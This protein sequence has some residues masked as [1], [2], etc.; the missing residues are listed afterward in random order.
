MRGKILLLFVITATTLWGQIDMDQVKASEEFAW[1]VRAFHQGRYNESILGFERALSFKPEDKLFRE[2]LGRAYYFSGFE[3]AAIQEWNKVLEGKEDPVIQNWSLTVAG[4]RANPEGD[5]SMDSRLVEALAIDGTTG[6]P[7]LFLRPGGFRTLPDGT[8]WLAAYGSNEIVRA[9]MNGAVLDRMTGGVEGFDAPFDL[10]WS[11]D[12]IIL[13]EFRRDALRIISTDGLTSTTIGSRGR[14]PGELLGP[15]YLSQDEYG[16]IYVTEWGNRRISKFDNQGNFILVFG[17]GGGGFSGVRAPTGIVTGGDRVYVADRQLGAIIV[18]DQSGNYLRTLGEG[19]FQSPEG[20]SWASE[21]ESLYVV[22]QEGVSHFSLDD[23]VNQPLW[24]QEDPDSLLM[25]QADLNGHLWMSD[26]DSS[27]MFSMV[28]LPALYSGFFV[29]INRVISQNF[30]QVWV[31]VAVEDYRGNPIVGLDLSNF[32]ISENNIPVG[33]YDLEASSYHIE[34]LKHSLLIEQSQAMELREE[35]LKQ[36]VGELV[37]N[38]NQGGYSDRRVIAAGVQPVL[39]AQP[40]TSMVDYGE[41]LVSETSGNLDLG[42]RLAGSS[43]LPGV[44]RKVITYL[45]TGRVANNSFSRYDLVQTA[46]FLK[47]NQIRFDVILLESAPVD[48]ELTYL[49][50][51]TGGKL[52]SFLQ[53]SGLTDYSSSL[54]ETPHGVYLLRY[55]SSADT[56]FGRRYLPTEVEV[57][58]LQRSG[59]DESGYFAPLK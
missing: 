16:N 22:H 6:D 28:E 55:N 19:L 37:T 47:N 2:W 41:N 48:P 36:A 49:M 25:A 24:R 51:Q 8:L 31:E 58:L 44:H 50:E 20:L 14:N 9:N 29:K 5:R 40:G 23:E 18:F 46:S 54:T 38:L 1:G 3:G 43:L 34:E 53:P 59:R 12:R 10:I 21:G 35:P 13:S 7:P 52:F 42:I 11:P 17:Q 4:R 15:Q 32:L 27:Q 57:Q 45:S 33:N 56:D 39:L 30:P 26:F